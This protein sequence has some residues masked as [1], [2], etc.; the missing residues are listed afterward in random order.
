MRC[1]LMHWEYEAATQD[2]IWN[3]TYES[4]V[5]YQDSS[6]NYANNSPASTAEPVHITFNFSSSQPAHSIQVVKLME[7]SSQV[8]TAMLMQ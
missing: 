2:E 5:M 6:W 1:F 4:Q 7:N 8:E 3:A